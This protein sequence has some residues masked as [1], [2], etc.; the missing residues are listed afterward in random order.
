MV[1]L[2]PVVKVETLEAATSSWD[3]VD[4]NADCATK[5]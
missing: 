5:L 3:V 2:L 1:R 4:A